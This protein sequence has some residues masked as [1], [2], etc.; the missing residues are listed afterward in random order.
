MVV[1]KFLKFGNIREEIYFGNILE[2]PQF[3]K[4]TKQISSLKPHFPI[5]LGNEEEIVLGSINKTRQKCI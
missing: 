3:Y 5:V 1:L 4:Y 2:D